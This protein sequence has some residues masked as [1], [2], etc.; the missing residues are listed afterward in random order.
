MNQIVLTLTAAGLSGRE[1]PH[2]AEYTTD[3]RSQSLRLFFI[4]SGNAFLS[5]HIFA[6][7]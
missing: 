1:H 2:P 3:Q 5:Y 4:L 7:L 6:V